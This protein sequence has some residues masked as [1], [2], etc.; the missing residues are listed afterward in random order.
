MQPLRGLQP[1]RQWVC[2]QACSKR[3]DPAE[4]GDDC[5]QKCRVTPRQDQEA[6]LPKGLPTGEDEIK[7]RRAVEAR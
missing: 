7:P 4:Q 6:L 5:Y 1:C 3:C 2:R